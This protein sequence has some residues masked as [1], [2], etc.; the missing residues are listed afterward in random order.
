M[1][2]FAAATKN[3]SSFP[4]R[5]PALRRVSYSV[6]N[7]CSVPNDWCDLYSDDCRTHAQL[8][9]PS[10]DPI[11]YEESEWGQFEYCRSRPSAVTDPSGFSCQISFN[12][13]LI[14]REGGGW[15]SPNS[16]CT[17]HCL[18]NAKIPRKSRAGG[19]VGCNQVPKSYSYTYV[20]TVL[21]CSSCEDFDD[22]KLLAD[23]ATIKDCSRVE[24]QKGVSAIFMPKLAACRF[25]PN[26]LFCS[27]AVNT[28]EQLALRACDLCDKP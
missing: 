25:T 8:V 14:S 10:R 3:S 28:A 19:T 15:I 20:K 18:E 16:T 27:V 21:R 26:P 17:F 23:W 13:K 11:G 22:T 12:C 24:C 4:T 6:A 5:A 9:S 1:V 7:T 2:T